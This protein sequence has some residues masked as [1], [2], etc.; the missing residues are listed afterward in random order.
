MEFGHDIGD[1]LAYSRNLGEAI[2]SDETIQRNGE[3][4]QA[5]G[6]P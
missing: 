4:C 6:G 3:C 1:R 5:V 2:I